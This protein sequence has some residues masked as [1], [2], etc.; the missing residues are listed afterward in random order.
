MRTLCY[1]YAILSL[2]AYKTLFGED[3]IDLHRLNNTRS[4]VLFKTFTEEPR[5]KGLPL[6]SK[7][8]IKKI[9]TMSEWN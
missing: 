5:L 9:L 1:V 3:D 6:Y 7:S 4:K 8:Q 2:D